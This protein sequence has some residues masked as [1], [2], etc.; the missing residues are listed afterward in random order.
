MAKLPSMDEKSLN[1]K[2]KLSEMNQ[3]LVEITNDYQTLLEK[4]V[5]YFNNLNELDRV[6]A[7]ENSKASKPLPRNIV[8]LD[9]IIRE[10]ES[11]KENIVET[12]RTLQNECNQLTEKINKQVRIVLLEFLYF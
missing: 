9:V 11:S 10:H 12:L 8:E 5:R 7:N 1:V 4:L 6:L 2:N 3:K